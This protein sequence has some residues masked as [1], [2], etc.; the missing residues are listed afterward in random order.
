[1]SK[2]AE[3]EFYARARLY[4]V[5]PVL[6]QPVGHQVAVPI[7]LGL[8]T[9]QPFGGPHRVA[10]AGLHVEDDVV[11]KPAQE[12]CVIVRLG[13]KPMASI[14]KVAKSL[15]IRQPA[16]IIGNCRSHIMS[17]RLILQR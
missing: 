1:M 7:E 16:A 15:S 5:R 12:H 10:G 13:E 3:P 8:Q 2:S 4:K 11:L 9:S 6:T 17:I 14:E